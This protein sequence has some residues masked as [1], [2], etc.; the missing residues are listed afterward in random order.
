M[1]IKNFTKEE[2]KNLANKDILLKNVIFGS[3]ESAKYFR[4]ELNK[5]IKFFEDK[6]FWSES[7]KKRILGSS[8]WYAF[9]STLNELKLGYFV[10]NNLGIIVEEYEAKTNNNKNVEFRG[11]NKKNEKCFIELKT[12]IKEN[13]SEFGHFNASGKACQAF[14][15]AN[16]QFPRGHMNL[17]FMSN[18]LEVSLFSD[19][20]AQNTVWN[21]LQQKKF[22][23]ISAVCLFGDI[24]MENMYKLYYA[25]NGQAIKKINPNIFKNCKKIYKFL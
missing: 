23:N 7:L 8:N 9:Y 2:L 13:K 4:T 12:K 3:F 10:E 14:A 24:Y 1:L 18:D 15:D 5:W 25:I 17:L 16:K 11:K 21:L 20:A 19:V 22:S 6:S